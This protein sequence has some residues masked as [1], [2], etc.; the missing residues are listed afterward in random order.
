M[1]EEQNKIVT[2]LCDKFSNSLFNDFRIPRISRIFKIHFL[3]K[4]SDNLVR[5]LA[6]MNLWSKGFLMSYSLSLGTISG[7]FWPECPWCVWP[8]LPQLKIPLTEYSISLMIYIVIV[9]N[10][11]PISYNKINLSSSLTIDTWWYTVPF[12][13]KMTW[14]SIFQN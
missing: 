6:K 5:F 8:K 12:K 10:F 11:W 9:S 2:V 3:S 1:A 7:E 13:L 4:P 14:S